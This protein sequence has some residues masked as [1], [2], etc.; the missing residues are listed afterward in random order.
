LHLRQFLTNPALNIHKAIYL[1]LDFLKRIR[2]TDR[3]IPEDKRDSSTTRWSLR[4]Y[5]L[6]D[7]KNPFL[8][9]ETDFCVFLN[10][11]PRNKVITEKHGKKG[12]FAYYI[13]IVGTPLFSSTV[14]IL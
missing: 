3:N 2:Y 10:N 12:F 9:K 4:P 5:K 11:R 1:Y 8:P 13:N 7:I 6:M 14:R